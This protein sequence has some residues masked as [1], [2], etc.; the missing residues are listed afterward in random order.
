VRVNS[1]LDIK[2]RVVTIHFMEKDKYRSVVRLSMLASSMLLLSALFVGCSC[3]CVKPPPP[4]CAHPRATLTA[5][6]HYFSSDS[7]LFRWW[8][9]PPPPADSFQ[10]QYPLDTTKVVLPDT[11]RCNKCQYVLYSMPYGGCIHPVWTVYYHHNCV[12][13]GNSWTHQYWSANGAPNPMPCPTPDK[14]TRCPAMCPADYVK[15]DVCGRLWLPPLW[16]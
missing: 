9:S 2:T 5:C 14:C 6:Y 8:L 13:G 7:S 15:C 10:A 1:G 3:P 4:L 12:A 16:Q 11:V